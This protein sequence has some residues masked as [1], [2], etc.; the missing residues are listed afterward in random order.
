[1]GAG[2]MTLNIHFMEHGHW[3]MGIPNVFCFLSSLP[4]PLPLPPRQCLAQCGLA[5]PYDWRGFVGTTK[6]TSVGLIVF[7]FVDDSKWI[8]FST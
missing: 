3:A 8:E 7:L 6:K 2:L 4:L 1:M 5:Y